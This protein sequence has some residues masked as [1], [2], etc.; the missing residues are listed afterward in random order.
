MVGDKKAVVDVQ[1]AAAWLCSSDIEEGLHLREGWFSYPASPVLSVFLGLEASPDWEPAYLDM[2]ID[3]ARSFLDR[4]AVHAGERA[5]TKSGVAAV[6]EGRTVVAVDALDG[7]GSDALDAL[8]GEALEEERERV[9]VEQ[10][11]KRTIDLLSAYRRALPFDTALQEESDFLLQAL[12]KV[13]HRI[14]QCREEDQR[15]ER[16]LHIQF[17]QALLR[18][19]EDRDQ[20]ARPYSLASLVNVLKKEERIIE[21]ADRLGLTDSRR[22]QYI[23]LYKVKEIIH[24]PTLAGA[25]EELLQQSTV[26]PVLM[27]KLAQII[28]MLHQYKIV[29]LWLHTEFARLINE[30]PTT[31]LEAKLEQWYV[32]LTRSHLFLENLSQLRMR[33]EQVDVTAFSEESSLAAAWNTFERDIMNYFFS[34]RFT[35]AFNRAEPLV[36]AIACQVLYEAVDKFDLVI[37]AMKGSTT[38]PIL[39]RVGWFKRMLQIYKGFLYTVMN[40]EVVKSVSA[41]GGVPAVPLKETIEY[42]KYGGRSKDPS[43]GKAIETRA[44]R[45]EDYQDLLES[46]I[47]RD[48]TEEDLEGTPGINIRSFTIRSGMNLDCNTLKPRFAEDAFSIIH[49]SLLVALNE[50]QKASVVKSRRDACVSCG[51]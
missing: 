9:I 21:Q 24:D 26:D 2:R 32:P 39:V 33:I 8:E 1:R 25:W 40:L 42:G 29:P 14:I 10:L 20:I 11:E 28:K 34:S 18:Q 17:L 30:A 7:L 37:K 16:L 49:Q 5:E 48:L 31:P 19:Q 50:L 44:Q 45:F 46:L 27:N 35:D 38:I 3:E 47:E 51:C 43:G 6:G 36:R 22:E 4:L 12:H 15:M 41:A 13:L 23:Q